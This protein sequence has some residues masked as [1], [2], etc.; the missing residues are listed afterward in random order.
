[1]S[2]LHCHSFKRFSNIIKASQKYK[3][4]DKYTYIHTHIQTYRHTYIKTYIQTNR[5]CL[6]RALSL[7]SSPQPP[8]HP[9]T[10]L[11]PPPEP[12]VSPA[13][14]QPRF[15]TNYKNRFHALQVGY[16]YVESPYFQPL[17]PTTSAFV[18]DSNPP[19]PLVSFL[20]TLRIKYMPQQLNDGIEEK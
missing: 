14:P 4:R 6:F 12:L 16:A 8:F 5:H 20:L 11:P 7:S 9:H 3:Q 13:P 10:L 15:L 18:T 19:L 2:K 17:L 1:M